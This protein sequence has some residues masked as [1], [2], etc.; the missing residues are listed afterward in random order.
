MSENDLCPLCGRTLGD[1]NVDFHHLIPKTF[2]GKD[3]VMLHRV[4]HRY[5]HATFSERELANYYHTIERLLEYENIQKFVKWIA[6]KPPEYYV[7]ANESI[8]RKKKRK[9]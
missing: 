6:K 8:E 7:S 9:R 4:C 5:I 1:I 2:K 3:G